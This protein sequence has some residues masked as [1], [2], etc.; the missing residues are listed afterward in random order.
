MSRQTEPLLDATA[1]VNCHTFPFEKL[2]VW[3]EARAL[4]VAVSRTVRSFPTTERYCLAP[5]LS[6]AALSVASNL[7]E[8]SSRTSRRDQAHFSQLAYG[9]LVE[10]ACQLVIARD[11]GYIDGGVYGSLRTSIEAI[12]NKVNALRRYQLHAS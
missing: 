6:R 8:G 11:L 10:L 5:Q 7:A 1:V 2:G 9:S 12:S 3:H 4:T